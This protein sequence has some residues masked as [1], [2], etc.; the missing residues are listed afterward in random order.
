MSVDAG[1]GE[2]VTSCAAAVGEVSEGVEFGAGGLV[3]ACMLLSCPLLLHTGTLYIILCPVYHGMLYV[4][5]TYA[6]WKRVNTYINA[7]RKTARRK[8]RTRGLCTASRETA[9]R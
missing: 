1:A 9:T 7:D 3:E 8:S 2:T 5:C 6:V 4:C